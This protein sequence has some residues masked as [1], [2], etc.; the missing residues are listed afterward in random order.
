MRLVPLTVVA[1]L[2]RPLLA[3]L[4][5]ACLVTPALADVYKWV[6]KQ[7]QTHYSDL[8]PQDGSKAAVRLNGA[9]PGTE[10]KAPVPEAGAAAPATTSP[11][12]DPKTAALR[13]KMIGVEQVDNSPEAQR[14]RA[15]NCQKMKSEL[16]VMSSDN[17]V[18]TLDA[19]GERQ[20]VDDATRSARV[21]ELRQQIGSSCN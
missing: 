9:P 16:A 18:F 13:G 3:C 10:A 6:D 17:R 20:Y 8:P 14:I 11:S 7:G 4:C 5:S 2:S 1:I 21:G 12:G 19:K 15:D